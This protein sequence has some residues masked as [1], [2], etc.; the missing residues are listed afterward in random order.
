LEAEL[1][2]LWGDRAAE[3]MGI[4]VQELDAEML[5]EREGEMDQQAAAGVFAPV[6]GRDIGELWPD[7]SRGDDREGTRTP[8]ADQVEQ[9]AEEERD[10]DFICGVRDD[11]DM[12]GDGERAGKVRRQEDLEEGSEQ[13]YAVRDSAGD[14]WAVESKEVEGDKGGAGGLLAKGMGGKAVG[15]AAVGGGKV[16]VN[17]TISK[18]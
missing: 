6:L 9:E 5:A 4:R 14:V 17:S 15:G 1:E 11:D 3:R 18:K 7:H 8:G 10:M 13:G 2:K 12:E 16:N